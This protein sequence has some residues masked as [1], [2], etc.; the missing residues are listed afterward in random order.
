MSILSHE[1]LKFSVDNM[2]GK[3]AKWLRIFGFDTVYNS[4]KSSNI[5][6]KEARR[7][8]RWF[9]TR[10]RKFK[11][12]EKSILIDS[13]LLANQI[14]ELNKLF[15]LNSLANPFSRCIIC[16]TPLKKIPKEEAKGEVPFFTYRNFNEFY[17]C[18]SC[19]KIFWKGS[20]HEHMLLKL[21][22][23]LK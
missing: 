9:I 12:E 7:T 8:N 17:R 23:M 14:R 10:N 4:A 22:E 19:K 13:E 18:N 15:N 3:L 20:H 16:N 6:Y 1:N 2:L 11:G 5:L 21:K